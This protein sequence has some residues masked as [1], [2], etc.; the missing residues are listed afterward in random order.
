MSDAAILTEGMPDLIKLTIVGIA[1][2]PPTIDPNA[3]VAAFALALDALVRL[4]IAVAC[5]AGKK[6]TYHLTGLGFEIYD[7][8]KRDKLSDGSVAANDSD[9]DPPP[10]AA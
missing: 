3:V 5:A 9:H 1:I 8:V 2:E 7:L 6:R 4:G 10:I